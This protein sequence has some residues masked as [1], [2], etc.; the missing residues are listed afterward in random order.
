MKSRVFGIVVVIAALVVSCG[1]LQEK[2]VVDFAMKNFKVESKTNCS[3]TDSVPCAVFEVQYP[4]F[5]SLDSNVRRSINERV[6]YFINES[7]EAKSLEQTG[8]DFIKDFED[9]SKDEPDFGMNWYFKGYVEVLIASDTLISLQV[10]T[11]WFT[12]GAH[13][14]NAV[15]YVNID[16]KTGTA[17]LLDA[18]LRSGYEA[19]L[20][21]LA[22]ED[23]REQ[24]GIEMDSVHTQFKLNENYGFR[25]EGI[26]FYYNYLDL[27]SFAE[28]PTEILIPYEKLQGWIR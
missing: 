20:A 26:V 14:S 17:Y 21:I 8:K 16:T 9:F 28:G 12:G 10:S 3:E 24:L 23:L 15:N 22:E 27:P 2:P 11:E 5:L 6:G 7:S 25:K 18:M 19:E 1:K 13:A 4:V